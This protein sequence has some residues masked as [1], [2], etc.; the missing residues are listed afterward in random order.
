MHTSKLRYIQ[1]APL[2]GKSNAN[3]E[4]VVPADSSQSVPEAV[5]MNTASTSPPNT[6]T[7]R[8]RF[9]GQGYKQVNAI[10]VTVHL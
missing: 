5:I 2:F 7:L 8:A 6:T 4:S 3:L 10:V 9:V 1:G